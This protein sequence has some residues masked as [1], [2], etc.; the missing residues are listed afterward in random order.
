MKR[1]VIILLIILLT[2]PMIPVTALADDDPSSV[3]L[4]LEGWEYDYYYLYI[5][6]SDDNWANVLNTTFTVGFDVNRPP[7]WDKGK[8][9]GWDGSRPPGLEQKDKTSP[10]FDQGNKKGWDSE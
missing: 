7:G 2:L 8:K 9:S 10:G 5:P 3:T 1:L 4:W 6:Y